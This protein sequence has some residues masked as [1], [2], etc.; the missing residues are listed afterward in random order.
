MIS[1]MLASSVASV[2]LYFRKKLVILQYWPHSIYLP[3]IAQ[4]S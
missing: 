1:M 3:Q 2:I 4:N